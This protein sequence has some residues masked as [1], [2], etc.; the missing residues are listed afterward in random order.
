MMAHHVICHVTCISKVPGSQSALAQ[1]VEEKMG[2]VG[3]QQA[4]NKEV[5]YTHVMR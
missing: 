5:L 4:C 2:E 1:G 3:S